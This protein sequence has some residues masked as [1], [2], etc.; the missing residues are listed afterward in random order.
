MAVAE[1]PKIDVLRAYLQSNFPN[2]E[3]TDKPRGAN[4]HDFR[5]VRSGSFYLVTFKRSFLNDHGPDELADLLQQ[6]Q[7]ERAIKK[8]ETSSLIVGNAG[9]CVAWPEAPPS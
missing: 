2:H 6:W 8:S 9:P 1:D 3:I 7:V 5:L 4:G